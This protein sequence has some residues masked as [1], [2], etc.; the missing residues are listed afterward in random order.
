MAGE[1]LY[2]VGED[3]STAEEDELSAITLLKL[4]LINN[5]IV[6]AV[7]ALSLYDYLITFEDERRHIWGKKF[8]GASLIF[9]LNRYCNIIL[10]L[11][12]CITFSPIQTD[13]LTVANPHFNLAFE[14]RGGSDANLASALNPDL[15]IID[16]TNIF[17]NAVSLGLTLMKTYRL[18]KDAQALN[19]SVPMATM[20]LRDG[21]IQF[22]ALTTIDIFEMIW[23]IVRHSDSLSYLMLALS[24]ILVTNF[25]LNLREVHLSSSSNGSTS[26]RIRLPSTRTQTMQ[27]IVFAT[28]TTI[29]SNIIGNLGAPLRMDAS[30]DDVGTSDDSL[31]VDLEAVGYNAGNRQ[32]AGQEFEEKT[33]L[34]MFS[35]SM[36]DEQDDLELNEVFEDLDYGQNLLDIIR[37][38]GTQDSIPSLISTN[39][40]VDVSQSDPERQPLSS[41][42]RTDYS[43]E[44]ER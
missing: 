19:V 1:E 4:L 31:A 40:R 34:K 37:R 38:K 23:V 8:T 42:G 17:A 39:L 13:A 35:G 20:L 29:S 11:I 3:S 24:S 21:S 14:A 15:I 43:S 27:S 33:P 6:V 28:P 22:V 5:Y 10:C 32:G 12:L 2:G 41:L 26:L 44:D 30:D 25:I 9:Y 7:V 36:S 18:H 16:G